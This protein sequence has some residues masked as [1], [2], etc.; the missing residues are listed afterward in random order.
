[1]VGQEQRIFIADTEL[2]DVLQ[3]FCVIVLD[4]P[5]GTVQNVPTFEALEKSLQTK[6]NP[7]SF[8]LIIMDLDFTKQAEIP[9]QHLGMQFL[10]DN[11]QRLQAYEVIAMSTQPQVLQTIETSQKS[12]NIHLLQKPFTSE[13]FRNSVTAAVEHFQQS[14]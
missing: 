1:M 6:L 7:D 3:R 12:P 5:E 10:S 4:F 13:Q 9:P 8:T 11:R 14:S 2:G